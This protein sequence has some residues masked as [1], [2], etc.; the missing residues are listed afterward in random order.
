MRVGVTGASGYIGRELGAAL[1]RDWS[2]VSLGRRAGAA[3]QPFRHCD[4]REA[5]P[6]GLLDGLDAVVHL[7]ADTGAGAVE[8]GEEIAFAVALARA[9]EARAIP[10]VFVSSQAASPTAPTAYGRTKAAI[11]A[12]ILPLG[13]VAIRPGQVYGGAERGLF[14][15]LCGALRRLPFTP[16]LLPAPEVQP[17]HVDDLARAIVLAVARP[18]L[19]GRM[20]RVAGDPVPF[21]A[22]LGCIARDRLRCTRP[23]VPVPVAALRFALRLGR[24]LLGPRVD[25]G[26]LDSLLLLPAMDA[27][28]DLAVLGIVP[29]ELRDGMSRSGTPRRRLLLEGRA[30]A[31]ALLGRSWKIPDP[32]L[33]RYV[34]MLAA[35]SLHGALAL[36]PVLLGYPVLLASLDRPAARQSSRKGDLAW[37][38]EAMCRLCE[39]EPRLAPAFLGTGEQHR[40]AAFADFA[41]AGLTE[42]AARLLHPLAR[43][44]GDGQ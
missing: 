26:R 36:R 16:R 37:R 18:D 24:R 17:I 9:A 39:A 32:L 28:P 33:R 40:L 6:D 19:R 44:F 3:T 11:E 31:R 21:D 4:L 29:R 13:A 1:P 42:V 20:L 5:L 41:R 10:C 14:G 34:R 15:T 7:A 43:R 38:M 12:A 23:P 30:M 35:H 22:F 25:P 27:G 2:M 8:R